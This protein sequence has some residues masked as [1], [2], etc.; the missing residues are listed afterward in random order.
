MFKASPLTSLKFGL[1]LEERMSQRKTKLLLTLE[2][3][4]TWS[5]L[6]CKLKIS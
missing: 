4:S 2:K 5:R 1:N 6:F 3:L